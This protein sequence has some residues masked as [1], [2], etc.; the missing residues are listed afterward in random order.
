M[1]M[2]T[3]SL[4]QLLPAVPEKV[5]YNYKIQESIRQLSD[6][7]HI[8]VISVKFPTFCVPLW[9]CPNTLL[10][11]LPM[12]LPPKNRNYRILSGMQKKPFPKNILLN[13]LFMHIVAK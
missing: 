6:A 8:S 3:L 13:I 9:L 12:P 7:T 5:I 2:K 1:S 11:W 4:I 10:E